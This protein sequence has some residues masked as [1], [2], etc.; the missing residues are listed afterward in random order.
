MRFDFKIAHV[1]LILV[2]VPLVFELLFIG[3][4]NHLVQQAETEIKYQSAVKDIVYTASSVNTFATQMATNVGG[5]SL[6]HSESFLK[7]FLDNDIKCKQAFDQLEEQ[8]KNDP[9]HLAMALE[10]RKY[11]LLGSQLLHDLCDSISRGS[12]G[13]DM[14]AGPGQLVKVKGI[15]DNM[16]K[17]LRSI[18]KDYLAVAEE[19]PK[20]E[21]Q[22]RKYYQVV[23]VFGVSFN[24]LLAVFLAILFSKAI[25]S[26][27]RIIN[28]NTLRVPKG[29]PLNEP[30]TGM[31]EIVQLDRVFHSM[32][33][34]LNASKKMQQYL[35][36]MVSHDLRSPLTSLQGMLTLLSVGALG[37]LPDKAQAK[38]ELAEAD[39]TRL[40][41]LTND[42]LDTERLASGKLDLKILSASMEELIDSSLESVRSFADQHKIKLKAETIP[43]EVEM[44]PNRIL[45]VL[46]NFLT[47]AIK[48]APE[49]SLV[50]VR[51][52]K[53]GNFV[54][55]SVI[56]QGRGVPREKQEVIFEKFQQV[57][58]ADAR[59][60]GGK[61]LGL[62]ICKSIVEQHGGTLGV[63]SESGNGSAFWFRIPI[64]TP[65]IHSA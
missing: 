27:V 18:I 35:I 21:A 1:G 28:E 12:G 39:L 11:G 7:K 45:Q 4:L 15:I 22:N 65:K 24:I 31:A 64:R 48:Y 53:D 47:N 44:D 25:T 63:V 19:S 3:L 13:R 57:D 29:L 54:R 60:M 55:A 56:D 34:E 41:K 33:D 32:V 62:A 5:Y 30:V 58:E 9:E 61:G 51:C 23:I 50:T 20:R 42:L 40:I 14:I 10:G 6:T 43:I 49:N 36:A 8:L 38:V 52:E 26:K 59:V 2:C 16:T 37:T 17:S 46:C